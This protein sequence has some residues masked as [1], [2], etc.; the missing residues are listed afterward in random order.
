MNFDVAIIASRDV[1]ASRLVY[2]ASNALAPI[3][4]TT[5]NGQRPVDICLAW[6]EVA[7]ASSLKIIV[8]NYD[9]SQQPK[10][11][12]QHPTSQI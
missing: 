3:C 12:F 8:G 5:T 11:A 4:E 2:S 1:H 7:H 10:S 6:T 9:S